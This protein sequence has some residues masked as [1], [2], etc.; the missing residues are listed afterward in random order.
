MTW[1][2]YYCYKTRHAPTN[3]LRIEVLGAASVNDDNIGTFLEIRLEG[4]VM[5]VCRATLVATLVGCP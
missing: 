5:G 1:Y 3:D 2:H 4:A